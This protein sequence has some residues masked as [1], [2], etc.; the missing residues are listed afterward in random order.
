MRIGKQEEKSSVSFEDLLELLQIKKRKSETIK[1]GRKKEKD[2][3]PN[4]IK[5]CLPSTNYTVRETMNVESLPRRVS[6]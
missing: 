1:T 4:K 2:K 6:P 5:D 3:P